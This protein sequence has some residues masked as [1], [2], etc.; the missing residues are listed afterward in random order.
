MRK[1]WCDAMRK[2][3][4]CACPRVIAQKKGRVVQP[5]RIVNNC[6]S[7][8]YTQSQPRAYNAVLT[9]ENIDL[10]GDVDGKIARYAQA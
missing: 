10:G 3:V 6:V 1:K 2:I 9:G 7:K 8:F 4:W 5:F